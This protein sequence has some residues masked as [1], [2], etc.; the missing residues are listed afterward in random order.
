MIRKPYRELNRNG[1]FQWKPR[2]ASTP[3]TETGSPTA[4]GTPREMS[5]RD[6]EQRFDWETMGATAAATAKGVGNFIGTYYKGAVVDIPLATTE[7]LRAIP[8]LYGEEVEDHVVRDWKTGAIAGGRNFAHGM[9][10]GLTGFFTQPVKDGVK[11]G[12][13]GVITGFA[14]GTIGI[15]TKLPAGK[16]TPWAPLS[17]SLI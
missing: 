9:G 2:S 17:S 13:F 1:P 3:V 6:P 12:P 5:A 10:K 8:R 14:K 15:G 7:G 11:E 4:D 16:S